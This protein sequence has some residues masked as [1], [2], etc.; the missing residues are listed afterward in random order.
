VPLRERLGWLASGTL[1]RLVRATALGV[2]LAAAATLL[3]SVPA[4]LAVTDV[5]QRFAIPH[6]ATPLEAERLIRAKAQFET[7]SLHQCFD[8]LPLS[9]HRP[10]FVGVGLSL[11][12]LV[13][14]SP[15]LLVLACWTRIK[16]AGTGFR[17][18]LKTVRR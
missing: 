10:G 6:N 4:A 18:N 15:A 17:F 8:P 16:L 7:Q 5:D 3:G 12:R 14:A 11:S 1:R 13:V 9:C 2:P